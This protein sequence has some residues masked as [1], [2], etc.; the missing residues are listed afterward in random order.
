MWLFADSTEAQWKSRNQSNYDYYADTVLVLCTNYCYH[1]L[2]H[3]RLKR[4]DVPF[5]WET[6]GWRRC[7]FCV[8]FCGA[9]ERSAAAAVHSSVQHG[10]LHFRCATCSRQS[11]FPGCD[12]LNLGLEC[13]TS[14]AAMQKNEKKH[15]KQKMLEVKWCIN[16]ALKLWKK[17]NIFKSL[18][19]TRVV[20]SLL[21]SNLVTLLI[22]LIWWLI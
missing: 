20:L 5:Y 6:T 13:G 19:A 3:F 1:K 4:V 12:F 10:C 17:L 16:V 22:S 2:N 11:S 18:K 14:A 21:R 15:E 9:P 8:V 7:D